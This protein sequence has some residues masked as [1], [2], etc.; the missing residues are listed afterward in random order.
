[1]GKRKKSVV[2]LFAA[3]ALLFAVSAYR[4]LSMRY[5]PEDALRSY[6][7]WVVLYAPAFRLAIYDQTRDLV[8]HAQPSNCAK[9][10]Q[11]P[12]FNGSLCP[13]CL[14]LCQYSVD[15]LYRILH[16]YRGYFHPA[17]RSLRRILSWQ[18]RRL[19]D[20]RKVVSASDSGVPFKRTGADE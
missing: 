10:R 6:L 5:L 13:G 16:Q 7:V 2:R 8:Y 3:T 19:S 11:Y 9:Y 4:Q 12:V 20:Q 14:P 17:V 15:A 1:M 18:G